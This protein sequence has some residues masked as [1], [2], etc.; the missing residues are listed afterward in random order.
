[1]RA[2]IALG[3]ICAGL[4]LTTACGGDTG[5]DTAVLDARMVGGDEG[6]LG[7]RDDVAPSDVGVADDGR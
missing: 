2:L 3:A 4:A 7:P 5:G 1:M 6:D